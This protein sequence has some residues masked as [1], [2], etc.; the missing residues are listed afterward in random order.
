M[1]TAGKI[2]VEYI[3]SSGVSDSDGSGVSEITALDISKS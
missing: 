3:T 2:F 1:L